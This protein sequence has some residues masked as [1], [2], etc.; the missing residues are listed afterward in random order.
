MGDP[1]AP[2]QDQESTIII[3]GPPADAPQER[4]DKFKADF[5]G[6]RKEARALFTKY[7]DFKITLKKIEYIEKPPK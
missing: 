1:T 4:K 5:E 2:G 6:F 3:E 7:S